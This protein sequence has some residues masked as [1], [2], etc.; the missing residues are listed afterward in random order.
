MKDGAE[1]KDEA[2]PRTAVKVRI[3]GRVQGVWFRVWMADQARDLGLRGWVRNRSDG[4]VEA[5]FA[6][7]PATVGEMV[8]L[9][10]KGPPMAAVARVVEAPA[11]EEPGHGFHLLPSA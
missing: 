8:R 2:M 9:C 1:R 3:E 11:D 10:W 5:L 7:A 6:G 4:S